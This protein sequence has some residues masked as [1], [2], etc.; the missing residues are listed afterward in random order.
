MPSKPHRSRQEQPVIP[1]NVSSQACVKSLGMN[2][3]AMAD[4]GAF[5]PEEY[6]LANGQPMTK[7]DCGLSESTAHLITKSL[8]SVDDAGQ[9]VPPLRRRDDEAGAQDG[10]LALA[11]PSMSPGPETSALIDRPDQLAKQVHPYGTQL[12]Q[13]RLAEQA[14]AVNLQRADGLRGAHIARHNA[15]VKQ[16]I[17]QSK[18]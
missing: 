5:V 1:E 3:T 4:G 16:L 10:P 9:R 2:E 13:A 15:V 6:K 14:V 12:I 7:S 11:T 17:A 8:D 18:H